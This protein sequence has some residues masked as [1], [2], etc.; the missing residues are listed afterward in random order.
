M[1]KR[2]PVPT[3]LLS[4]FALGALCLFAAVISAQK[5]PNTVAGVP[6]RGIDMKLGRNPGGG[7]QARKTDPNGKIDLSDLTPGSYWM[8]I[9]PLTEAQKA[10]NAGGETYSYIA[11]TLTGTQLV[12]GPRTRSVDLKN[13]KFVEPQ[14]ATERRQP[15]PNT[16]A[17]RIV[18]EIAPRT[19]GSPPEPVN[20]TVVKSKSNIT[21]N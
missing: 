7:G 11:V 19:G 20:A 12:G 1:S 16:F 3:F 4:A 10:A 2:N 17:A 5:T 9:V 13:W 21:N 14:V 18:F 6:I 15:L 8:E